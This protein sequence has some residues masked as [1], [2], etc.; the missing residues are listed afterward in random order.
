MNVGGIEIVYSVGDGVLVGGDFGLAWFD[1]QRFRTLRSDLSEP[2]RRIAGIVETGDGT[3]WLNTLSGV[4]RVDSGELRSA[5]LRGRWPEHYRLFDR[6]DGL[7][8]LAQQDSYTQT[9]LAGSDG[10]LWFITNQGIAWIDP[11]RLRGNPLPPPVSI[12]G[13]VSQGRSYIARSG[14][15]LPA[16]AR[17]I[18]INYTAPSLRVPERVAFR[19]KLN[20]VDKGWIDPGS[21][22]QAFYTQ[23]GPGDYVFRV[24]AAN[25]AGVWNRT[26]ATLHFAIR[27]TFTET[28]TFLAACILAALSI[29]ALI[30]RVHL[31]RVSTRLRER[32]E[33]RLRERERIA[34]EL[35]DTLLQGFQ[36]LQLHFQYAMETIAEGS[37]ARVNF[38]RTLSLA[39]GVLADARNRVRDLRSTGGAGGLPQHLRLRGERMIG[40]R[41]ISLRIEEDGDARDLDAAIERE[42]AAI[43]EEAIF[44][45][46]K[47]SAGS[48]I[49][50][51]VKHARR[52]LELAVS[53]DG[54]GIS[55]AVAH[56]GL[57]GHFGLVGMRERARRIRGTLTVQTRAGGG[58][59]V[60]LTVPAGIAYGSLLGWLDHLRPRASV[61]PTPGPDATDRTTE[62]SHQP[63]GR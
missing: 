42:V 41:P 47:H 50:V 6:R 25:D 43:A 18:Q 58:T 45:A 16:S 37:P 29:L 2:F 40:D 59:E 49:E 44:N 62:I 51:R 21:R 9:A 36:G 31:R 19:Y 35:H 24:V 26:G 22:R 13:I 3:T 28:R 5:L 23:L 32:I 4:I 39:D 20:G 56:G 55:D 30:Y 46:V 57:D 34:R 52:G 1:G 14:L 12:Q 27:P 38:E 60:V 63:D 33:E 7:P 15:V 53:D 48:L 8:G 61:N 10:R 54:K 11:R 17:S